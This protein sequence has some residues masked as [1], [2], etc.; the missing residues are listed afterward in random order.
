MKIVRLVLQVINNALGTAA[1]HTFA[2]RPTTG[3]AVRLVPVRGANRC[4][5][6]RC[7]ETETGTPGF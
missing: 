4:S 2:M 1:V 6:H 5:D 7:A 3:S